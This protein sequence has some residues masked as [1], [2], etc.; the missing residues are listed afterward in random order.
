MYVVAGVG[1]IVEIWFV[2]LGVVASIV[3]D[4]GPWLQLRSIAWM[5]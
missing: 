3:S 5:R 2:L 1:G 4:I